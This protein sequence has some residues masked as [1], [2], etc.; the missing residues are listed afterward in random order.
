MKFKFFRVL[1]L[2]LI[3]SMLF[4]CSC[5]NNK[6]ASVY[7][8]NFKPELATAY[9]EIASAYEAETGVKV[10][11][12]TAA[13]NQYEQTLKSEIAKSSAPTIFQIN[14]PVGYREWKDYCADLTDTKLYSI[15]ADKSLAVTANGGVYG[16]PYVIEGY[17]IIYNDAIMKKYFA[18][19]DKAS[20]LSSAEEIKNFEELKT[21]VEDMSKHLSELGIEGV[22]GS[23]SMSS[24]E[25][26]RWTNHLANMPLYYEFKDGENPTSALL[27]ADK[28]DFSHKNEFKQIFD[29]YLDNS[30]TPKNLLG[31]KSVA[32]SMSEFALSKVAMIQNGNWAWSQISEVPGNTVKEE[33]IK[34]MPIYIGADDEESQGLCIG[35]ENYFAI[36]KNVPPEQQKESLDF[37][38]WLFS[39]STGKKLVYEKLGFIT[40]FST[41]SENEQPNDPLGR[42]VAKD[43]TDSSTQTVPWVFTAMPGEN[44]KKDFGDALLDY[45]QGNKEFGEVSE[46]FK[47]AY[48]RE[49]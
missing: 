14:G 6:K 7:F 16:I 45:V 27:Y 29:L 41:F 17:G 10:K 19:N 49:R 22:F 20:K 24:G 36:N 39:S 23:T 11:I 42:Q 46:I 8:L 44:F 32:D 15:L 9:Q 3:V 31:S 43:L 21:V 1:S 48:E 13:A 38:Y 40:P 18:L 30:I 12:T 5:G 28:I 26:W 33:D 4:L 25:N 34:F 35:T 2:A 37:L 47:N